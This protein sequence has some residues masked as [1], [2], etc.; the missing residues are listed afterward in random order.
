ML[1]QGGRVKKILV[2]GNDTN[3]GARSHRDDRVARERGVDPADILVDG[4]GSRTRETMDRA[5]G[6][7]EIS[8]AVICTQDVNAARSVYLAEAAGIDAVAVGVPSNST[9][10]MRTCATRRSRP[11]SPSS[12]RCSV[13][14]RPARPLG[15]GP[16]PPSRPADLG[17][18]R[19]RSPHRAIFDILA[20]RSW[21]LPRMSALSPAVT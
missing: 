17:A 16:A 13:E 15:H 1:Y 21:K 10:R 3:G 14:E 20:G 19:D 6:V 8:D 2:S 5:A 18:R 4:G 7:F 9:G 12:N 11:P